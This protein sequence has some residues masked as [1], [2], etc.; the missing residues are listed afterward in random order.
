MTITSL[1]PHGPAA[2]PVGAPYV[3]GDQVLVTGP[4]GITRV[5]VVHDM[6]LTAG[7]GYSLFAHIVQPAKTG[8]YLICTPVAADGCSD[9]V[10]SA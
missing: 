9:T 10:R 5:A 4:D 6:T 1:H 3:P 7:G 2:P 8:S